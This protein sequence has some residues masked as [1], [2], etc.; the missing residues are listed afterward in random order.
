MEENLK[1]NINDITKIRIGTLEINK[2]F[3][4]YKIILMT[5]KNDE[6]RKYLHLDIELND[7]GVIEFEDP[8]FMDY[9]FRFEDFNNTYGYNSP[10]I[11]DLKTFLNISFIYDPLSRYMLKQKIFS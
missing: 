5:N 1:N 11:K 2:P 4:N 7:K 8:F 9:H 3:S 10:K 6:L